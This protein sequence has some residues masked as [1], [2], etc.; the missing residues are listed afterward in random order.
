MNKFIYLC[1]LILTYFLII[2]YIKCKHRSNY[3]LKEGSYTHSS[4]LHILVL[5]APESCKTNEIILW[6]K[7]KQSLHISDIIFWISMTK[8]WNFL[9][10][11]IAYFSCVSNYLVKT[12]RQLPVDFFD[13]SQ[14]SLGFRWVSNPRTQ[15]RLHKKGIIT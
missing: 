5:P 13:A 14:T 2:H 10:D 12:V 4:R 9:I 1:F 7:I 15:C 11:K 6:Q 8:L 3:H